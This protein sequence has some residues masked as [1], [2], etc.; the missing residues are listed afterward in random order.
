MPAL[1]GFAYRAAAALSGIA[2]SVLT[3]FGGGNV[4]PEILRAN[5]A[6]EHHDFEL[7]LNDRNNMITLQQ[8]ADGFI[9]M[10]R[11]FPNSSPVTI[12]FADGAAEVFSG[13]QINAAYDEAL[14]SY[15][16]GNNLDAKGFSRGP[17]KTVHP[18]NKIEFVP[19]H[20]GMGA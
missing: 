1:I 12:L 20:P 10:N 5:A 9:R 14:A 6:R 2:Q 8:D 18:R 7:A 13:R 19:V 3:S 11:H 15:R 17:A 4:D 16:A